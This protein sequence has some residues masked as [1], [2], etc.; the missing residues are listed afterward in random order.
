MQIRK[1]AT[2]LGAA[3][4]MST[5]SMAAI[6]ADE[7]PMPG[8]IAQDLKDLAKEIRCAGFDKNN[9]GLWTDDAIW[10]KKRELSCADHSTAADALFVESAPR[11]NPS[12]P[13][14]VRGAAAAVEQGEFEEAIRDLEGFTLDLLNNDLNPNIEGD[15]N[16]A[17][18]THKWIGRAKFAQACVMEYIL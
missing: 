1:S 4:V 12:K 14:K 3:L 17:Y 18:W 16:A 5:F 13:S 8:G 11:G 10:L 2:A 15:K 7:C 6:A 9:E